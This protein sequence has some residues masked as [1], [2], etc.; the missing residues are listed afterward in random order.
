MKSTAEP[1]TTIFNEILDVAITVVSGALLVTLDT[2]RQRTWGGGLMGCL[3]S[4]RA[5]RWPFEG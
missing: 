3:K 4:A 1:S 2:E 5:M